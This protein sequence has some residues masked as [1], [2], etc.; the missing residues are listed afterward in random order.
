MIVGLSD[1]EDEDKQGLLRM[2]DVLLTSSKTVGEKR[3]ILKSDF[4][5]EMTDEMNEEV[6]I[7]CNLSQGILEKG[8]KQGRAEGIKEG[9]AEGL[10]E[11]IANSL[12]NV[13]KTLKMTAEQAMETLNIPQ[14][15][16]EKYKTM[17]KVT[18]SLV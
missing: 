13:M 15:E 11:G 16:H 6:S 18:G 8:L 5:I 1:E 17:L 12:L 4:D 14:N 7:M 10:A 3:E 9:R 2:L